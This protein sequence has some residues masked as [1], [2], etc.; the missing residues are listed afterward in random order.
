MGSPIAHSKSPAIHTAFASQTGQKMDYQAVLVPVG[1]F[2]EALVEFHRQGGKGA[3]ITLPFKHEAYLACA[4]RSD[5][6]E[7]AGAVNTVWFDGQGQIHGDNT[8]GIGLVRDLRDNLRCTLAGKD[9]LVLG[10]GGAVRGIIDPLFDAGVES[11]II[12]NRTVDRAE[13]IAAAFADRGPIRASSFAELAGRQFPIIING[14]SLSLQNTVPPLPDDVMEVGGMAYDMM[15][16]D[17]P[18]VFMR[19]AQA[20]GAGQAADG[21]GMLVEQAAE[22]FYIWRGVRPRTG[23]VIEQLRPRG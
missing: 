1:R 19:W 8:D 18:T 2:R 23:P 4:E 13:A 9:I 22:S 10:A 3:N 16:S 21:L 12:A 15:Y 6:A 11:I 14:T 17:E 5:R 20:H 7:R